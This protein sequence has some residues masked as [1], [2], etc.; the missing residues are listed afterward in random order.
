MEEPEFTKKRESFLFWGLLLPFWEDAI[1]AQYL[2]GFWLFLEDL[3]WWIYVFNGV[4]S[5]GKLFLMKIHQEL[6][7]KAYISHFSPID[8]CFQGHK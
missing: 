2:C 8:T 6:G 1:K 7:G 4:E 5:N 3:K